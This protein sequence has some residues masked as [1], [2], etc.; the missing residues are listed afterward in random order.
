MG[1]S[2]AAVHGVVVHLRSGVDHRLVLKRFVSR[3]WLEQEPDVPGRE[4]GALTIAAAVGLPAPRLVADDLAPTVCDVPAVLMTRLAGRPRATRSGVPATTSSLATLL[5]RVH[6]VDHP[7]VADLPLV[8]RWYD[9]LPGAPAW[10][11]H[12]R[13]WALAAATERPATSTVFLHRDYHPGNVVWHQGVLSGLV[14]W[15]NASRGPAELDVAHCRQNLV[16]LDGLALADRFLAMWQAEAGRE[17]YDPAFDLVEATEGRAPTER[18]PADVR[19]RVDDFV[20]RAAA[21]VGGTGS[22]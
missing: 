16:W 6:A 12:P 1:G 18:E 13:A 11:R 9:D 15:A 7:A 21:R 14:D 5:V 20:A 22:G 10:S 2:S 8:R 4:A 19:A 17:D 3:E